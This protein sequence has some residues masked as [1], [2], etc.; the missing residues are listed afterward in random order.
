MRCIAI[1]DEPVALSI[2]EQ[3]CCRYGGVELETYSSP[4]KGLERIMEWQPEL[5]FLDIEMNGASGLEIASKLP[6]S[7]CLIFTTAYAHYALEGFEVNAVDFL[8]KPYFYQRFERAMQK[9]EQW[10]K[11]RD[12]LKMSQQHRQIQIKS[13]Y[14][15]LSV[16]IDSIIYVESFDNYV[17]FHLADGS[18]FS[19]KS[20]LK[21]IEE[22]LAGE[23]FLRIHRSFLIS[24][25]R[26]RSFS[27]SEVSLDKC[28]ES[29][30]IGKKYVDDVIRALELRS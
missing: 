24:L 29:L 28:C 8:H 15:T 25:R 23:D 16:P 22:M 2:I 21:N 9:V 20:S 17:K 7:C 14:K 27:R 13:E 10:L 1:D 11:M 12:L 18:A 19:S 26:V 30:P 3:Y 6:P 5:V 4:H